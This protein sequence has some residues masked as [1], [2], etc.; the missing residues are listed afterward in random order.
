MR[1]LFLALLLFSVLHA[2]SV[3]SLVARAIKNHPSLDA[4][5]HRLTAMDAR[6]AKSQKWA[7]PDLSVTINDI[8]FSDISN[9]SIEPMQFEAFNVKQKFPWFGKTDAKQ[10]I[11][12][13]RKHLLLESYDAAKVA[14][15]LQIR[16]SAYTIKELEHRIAIL[17]KYIQLARTNITLFTDTIATDSMSHADSVT[18]ELSL[19]KIEVQMERYRAILKA[20]REKL[21]YLVGQKVTHISTPLRLHKPPALAYYLNKMMHNPSLGMKAK[22]TDVAQAKEKLTDLE[23]MPDP[24]VKM[25]YYHRESFE[26][27]GALTVGIAAPLY[28]TEALNSEIARK[29]RLSSQSDYLDYKAKLE[30]EIRAEYVRLTESYRIYYIIKD[31]SLP[32]LDHMLELS[33]AA[34]EKGADLFT[35]TNILEQKLALEEERIAA[36]AEF[37]RTKAKLKALTGEI[38]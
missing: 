17:H 24:Y 4:I 16:Q 23:A 13:A 2:Q 5:K 34:I 35:Y 27:Y 22:Q 36:A 9:R 32:Q 28:G 26:D 12:K 25:G 11:E 38:R 8:Q 19:Y 15:A 18:A 1:T 21:A 37:M 30:S 3:D 6:I 33:A 20:Q 7:N 10:R 14:L 31:K 29:E